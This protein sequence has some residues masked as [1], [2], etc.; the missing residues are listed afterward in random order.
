MKRLFLCV[1][2]L[3]SPALAQKPDYRGEVKTHSTS[4]KGVKA[5]PI[6]PK[7][8]VQNEGGSDGAGLCVISS[9]IQNGQ[10]QGV[11]ATRGGKNSPLWRYAKAR[12]GGYGP[13]KLRAAVD[14][15]APKEGFA[16]YVGTNTAVLEKITVD[17]KTPVGATMNTGGLY[18]YA[19]IHHMI[20][21]LHFSR[22]DGTA[23]VMD[24]NDQITRDERGKLRAV[25]RW[26][27]ANEFARRWI[28]GGIGWAWV[29]TRHARKAVED[30]AEV[31][32]AALAIAVAFAILVVTRSHRNAHAEPETFSIEEL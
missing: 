26:M 23:C 32:G 9:L 8:H 14:A 13:D 2:F 20:S 6:P 21:L 1:L 18:N 31:A 25:Y 4:R 5:V 30:S 15:V 16:S 24:N 3:T 27:P 12:P 19:P 11:P 22:K 17:R 7:Y 28:D 29:W 10:Y